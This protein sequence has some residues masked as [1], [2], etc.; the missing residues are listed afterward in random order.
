[1]LPYIKSNSKSTNPDTKSSSK[2]HSKCMNSDT[3][4]IPNSSQNLQIS[5]QNQIQNSQIQMQGQ[6]VSIQNYEAHVQNQQIPS[7]IHN[8]S[9]YQIRT[10]KYSASV[11]LTQPHDEIWT[12]TS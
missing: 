6:Q 4:S 12:T 11:K 7:K 2:Y 8:Y 9:C 1:M 10:L 3:K 5:T